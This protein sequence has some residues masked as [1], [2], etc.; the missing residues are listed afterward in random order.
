LGW[1]RPCSGSALVVSIAVALTTLA[2]S[3]PAEKRRIATEIADLRATRKVLSTEVA[4]LE[5]DATSV[6]SAGTTTAQV[7]P[8]DLPPVPTPTPTQTPSPTSTPTP[9][10]PTPT[11][12]LPQFT[13]ELLGCTTGLDITHALGEVTNAYVLVRNEGNAD[14]TN[15]CLRLEATD[16]GESHPDET[17][18]LPRL[19]ARTQ[20]RIKL[21]ADTEIRA[22]TA[23]AVYLTSDDG[24]TADVAGADCKELDLPL[25]K[26]MEG[27][28]DLVEP[29]PSE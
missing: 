25:Q 8:T 16:V 23:I 9:V 1:T 18:C 11:P 10:P 26:E 13:L 6:G 28:F 20:V 12:F 17:H 7:T 19:P 22:D 2:C 29:L 3:A 5:I 14:A 27:T 24:P 4:G 21:T 15:V